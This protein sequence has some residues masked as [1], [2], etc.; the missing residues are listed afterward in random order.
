MKLVRYVVGLLYDFKRT[1]VIT[2][3]MHQ[4]RLRYPD[5]QIGYSTLIRCDTIDAIRLGSNINIGPFCE[6][7]VY[8]RH[9]LTPVEGSLTL[10]TGTALGAFVNIRAAGGAIVIGENCMIAQ[11]A[12][13]VAANHGIKAGEIYW[14]LPLEQNRTGIRIGSNVW[15]GAGVAVVPGTSI[16]DNTIV[17]AGAVVTRDIPAN[18]IW[19]GVP[20]KKIGTIPA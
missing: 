9:G 15:L 10:G 5:L 12:S 13:I 20:A 6:I 4:L 11:H 14:R 18:E 16:G 19:A 2:L 1:T 3:R 7:V 17:G 8:R